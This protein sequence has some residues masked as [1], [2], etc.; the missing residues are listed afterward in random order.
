[1]KPSSFDRV[2]TNVA[3]SFAPSRAFAGTTA[4]PA[5]DSI[6][7]SFSASPNAQT[8]SGRM[9]RPAVTAS[10]P[11]ALLVSGFTMT[12][13]GPP[14]SWIVDGSQRRPAGVTARTACVET[15]HVDGVIAQT[16]GRAARS[17]PEPSFSSLPMH[18][19]QFTRSAAATVAKKSST[20]FLPLSIFSKK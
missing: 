20:G 15:G 14:G 3:L 19:T 2:E 12:D 9:P 10:I 8:S 7:W 17:R 11:T 6:S 13:S 18:R 1:M 5:Q 4:N 16:P